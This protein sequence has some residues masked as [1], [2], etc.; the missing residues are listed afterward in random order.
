MAAL[1]QGMKLGMY[2]EEIVQHRREHVKAELDWVERL[3]E[4][5]K[6]QKG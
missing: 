2:G 5:Q 1:Q 6:N 4:F 3:R